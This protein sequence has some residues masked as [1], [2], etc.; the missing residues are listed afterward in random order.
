MTTVMNTKVLRHYIERACE[1]GL[2]NWLP[3]KPYLCLLY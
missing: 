3:D 2:F 1:K